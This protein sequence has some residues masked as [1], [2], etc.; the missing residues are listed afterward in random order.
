ME[1][2]LIN[3]NHFYYSVEV[4]KRK[5]MQIKL[6]KPYTIIITTPNI[7]N[8]DMV[9]NILLQKSSWLIKHNLN[10]ISCQSKTSALVNKVLFLGK[11][12]TLTF[13]DVNYVILNSDTLVLP[14]S[15]TNKANLI[16][17]KWLLHQATSFLMEKTNFWSNQLK[18]KPNLIK[19]KDQKT[20]WGSCSSNGNINYN[21]RII[22]APEN[23]IDYLVIHELSH[24]KVPNHSVAFWNTV[25]SFD[26]NYKNNRNW[27]KEHGLILTN[28][29]N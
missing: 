11:E 21:W 12:Y 23:I 25:S 18:V 7:L 1:T 8:N 15:Y 2:I 9:K 19:L 29:L 20:R 16:L 10:I 6:I 3:N 13:E 4:K 14:K 26:P 28:F 5:S 24:W 22:M 17:K 27:L